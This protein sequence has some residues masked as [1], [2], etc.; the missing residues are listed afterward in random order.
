M[1]AK[2]GDLGDVIVAINGKRIEGLSTFVAELGRLGVDST[3]ELTVVR[4][5]RERKVRVRVIEVGS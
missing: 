1:N 4:G 5:D 3:A 2:T